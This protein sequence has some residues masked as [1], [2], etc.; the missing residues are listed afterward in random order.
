M[1]TWGRSSVPPP[2]DD[3]PLVVP[4]E[5]VGGQAVGRREFVVLVAIVLAI[6]LFYL[7]P[8][9]QQAPVTA[10]APTPESAPT[11][12]PTR[13]P[14]PASPTPR[15]TADAATL[16]ERRRF[17]QPAD[18]WRLVSIEETSRWRTRTM[19]G[20]T[21]QRASGPD[22]ARI[23]ARRDN[24]E[25]LMA[26]GVCAPMDSTV[27][28]SD[29]LARVVLWHVPLDG[30]PRAISRPSV[31]DEPLLAFGEAYYG[32]PPGEG[33]EWPPGRYV[34]EIRPQRSGTSRWLALDFVPLAAAHRP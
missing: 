23:V 27:A 24:T 5:R 31:L 17:C 14:L 8:W 11:A 7:K 20:A 13:Q 1:S 15:P 34:I 21:P 33:A 22:D 6:G 10:L 18:T 19:W 16:A 26:V 2:R 30:P 29:Q 4:L 12:T 3:A 32:P 9:D 28:L 25:R